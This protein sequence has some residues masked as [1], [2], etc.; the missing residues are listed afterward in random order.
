VGVGWGWAKRPPRAAE[1]MGR[2]LAGKINRLSY[3]KKRV[4][5]VQLQLPSGM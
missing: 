1:L 3:T 2:Q 4:L 5:C